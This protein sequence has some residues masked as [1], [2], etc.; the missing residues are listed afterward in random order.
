MTPEEREEA[1]EFLTGH[2]RY[3]GTYAA[4]VKIRKLDGLTTDDRAACMELLRLEDPY[5]E[6]GCHEVI[7]RFEAENPKWRI[8]TDGRSAGYCV[9]HEML[10]QMQNRRVW[11]CNVDED[12]DFSTWEDC[13][14]EERAKVV[15]AFDAACKEGVDAFVNFARTHKVVMDEEVTYT[16]YWTAVPLEE[17][18]DGKE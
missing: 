2:Y 5:T 3:A 8:V 14:L 1:I 17:E 16:R 4:C 18:S 11:N 10:P 12:V 9:L 15:R 13:D 7:D 6:A